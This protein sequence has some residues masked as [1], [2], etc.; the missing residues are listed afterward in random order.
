MTK[1]LSPR[2]AELE[3]DIDVEFGE[4]DFAA[5]WRDAVASEVRETKEIFGVEVVVPTDLPLNFEPMV[6]AMGASSDEDDIKRLLSV[7][8]G[9]D[10]LEAW[11]ARGCTGRQFQV[12]F[13]W[14]YSNGRGDRVDFAAAKK[15]ADDAAKADAE[16]KGPV[17][18]VPNRADRRRKAASSATT[19]SAK[20]GPSSSRTSAA[21]TASRRKTS[22]G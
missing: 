15:L 3:P 20:G 10:V 2:D 19:A 7:L 22:P 14:G 5:F 16:G 8:F 18:T 17:R 11:K 9:Q 1:Q 13:M 21:S 4:E 12:L 6:E